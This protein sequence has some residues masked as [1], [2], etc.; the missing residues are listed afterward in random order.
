MNNL[1]ELFPHKQKFWGILS[2]SPV[3][4]WVELGTSDDTQC[5][6]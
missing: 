1:N 4:T 3:R 5:I 6:I 2:L